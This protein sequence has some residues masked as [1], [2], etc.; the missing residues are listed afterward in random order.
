V[1]ILRPGRDRFQLRPTNHGELLAWV[2][3]KRVSMECFKE[4]TEPTITQHRDEVGRGDSFTFH[5]APGTTSH[6]FEIPA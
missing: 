4:G 3:P 6:L 2:L 5:Y 1:K